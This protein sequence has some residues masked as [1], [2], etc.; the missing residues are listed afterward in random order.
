MIK[1]VIM[2]IKPILEEYHTVTPY[3]VIQGAAQANQP[4]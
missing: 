3:L 2:T 1:E 4:G